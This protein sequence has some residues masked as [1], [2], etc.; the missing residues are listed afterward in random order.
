MYRHKNSIARLEHFTLPNLI[1]A[2]RKFVFQYYFVT[3]SQVSSI[4]KRN[5][6][7]LKHNAWTDLSC[8]SG[9]VVQK[10]LRT[11][12]CLSLDAH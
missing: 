1:R 5:I 6:E 2:T 9:A 4:Q 11:A 3:L 12:H 8:F 10:A 7:A